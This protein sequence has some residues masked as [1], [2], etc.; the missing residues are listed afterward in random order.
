MPSIVGTWKLV[1]AIARDANG[2]ALPA[3][4]GG[5][6]M[7]RVTFT[8]DGRMMSVVCDGRRELPPGASRDYSSYCGNYTFDGARLVTR[9]DAASD[10]SRIGSDQARGVRFEGGHMILS[11]P[12][13]GTGADTEH[14]EITWE[15]IAAE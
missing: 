5:S 1:R 9:V 8:A 7:G 4:Y 12:P 15:R 3:P 14:R 13:R 6:A 2:A 11:P 10:P